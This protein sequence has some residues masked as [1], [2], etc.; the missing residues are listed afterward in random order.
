MAAV[1]L[2]VFS[3]LVI[4][5]FVF[6]V[7]SAGGVKCPSTCFCLGNLVDCSKRGLIEV[8]KDVPSWVTRL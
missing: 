4:E 5:V 7:S 6:P 2:C 8:P 3:V 1:L